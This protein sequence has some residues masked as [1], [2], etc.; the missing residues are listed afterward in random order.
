[1]GG[2]RKQVGKYQRWQRQRT[3][4]KKELEEDDSLI[5]WKELG[6]RQEQGYK[7][8]HGLLMHTKLVE[9]EHYSDALVVPK[10]F[11]GRILKIAHD[12]GGHFST[13]KTVKM[14]RK[15]FVWPGI[16]K[17]TQDYCASCSKCQSNSSY[18]P[19]RVPMVARPVLSEPFESVALDLVGP[20]E[21][22]EGGNCY[23]LTCICLSSKWPDAIPLRTITT[24]S[25]ADAM[26]Q[27]FSRVGIPRQILMDC[28]AQFTAKSMGEVCDMLGIDRVKTTPYHP[29]TNGNIERMHRTLKS[30]LRK[31][32]EE[33]RDWVQHVPY[34]LFALRNLP[35]EGPHPLSSCS[36]KQDAIGCTISRH[37]RKSRKKS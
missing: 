26:W 33:K 27:V 30:I 24:R 8:R 11:Q 9:Y 7:W 22:G 1:M 32:I 4:E 20:M 35:L 3:M 23:L 14:I 34:A 18:M 17:D 28:G 16:V 25:V 10:E 12:N 6:R 36:E 29:A 13:D 21:K 2:I 15:R 19:R 31:V 5:M 37:S